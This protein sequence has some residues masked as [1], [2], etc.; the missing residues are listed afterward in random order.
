M[1]TLQDLIKK[2]AAQYKEQ[3]VA[4]RRHIHSHPE[5][6][7]EEKNTSLFIQKILGELGIPFV[8]DV[9]DY[10][11]IGKIEGD[12]PGPVIALRADIDALPIHETTG[13]PF[14][15]ENDGVM[16]LVVMIATLR[17]CLV[18]QPFYSLLKTNCM[19]P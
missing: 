13:L 10:A 15:S 3:V 5:L 11:V 17:F 18:P 8:N 7:G 12:Q 9:S 19:A 6:S 4:W 2:Y 16:L 14:A 1:N